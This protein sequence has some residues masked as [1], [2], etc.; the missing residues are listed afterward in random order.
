ME[1]SLRT[2]GAAIDLAALERRLVAIDPAALLDLDESGQTLR[3]ATTATGDELLACLR[4][5]GMAAAAGDL[6]Q[7]PSVCC[8]GCSG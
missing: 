7:L 5:A 8:G 2:K 1:F 4:A 3:I 6:D